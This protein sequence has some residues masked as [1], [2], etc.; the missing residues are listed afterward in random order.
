[1]VPIR[2]YWPISVA[3][4]TPDTDV[5][6]VKYLAVSGGVVWDIEWPKTRFRFADDTVA[7]HKSNFVGISV[8]GSRRYTRN[9][10]KW[11]LSMKFTS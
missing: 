1:M 6:L 5:I 8:D 9:C 4:D 2:R 7:L 3:R 11:A 10:W